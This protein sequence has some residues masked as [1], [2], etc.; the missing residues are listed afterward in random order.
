M[1]QSQQQEGPEPLSLVRLQLPL[2]GV[3]ERGEPL[4][5]G[6]EG[7]AGRGTGHAGLVGSR[8][9]ALL[10]LGKALAEKPHLLSERE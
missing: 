4:L 8:P 2:A 9:A 1:L 7:A 3:E 5:E 10:E 6:E